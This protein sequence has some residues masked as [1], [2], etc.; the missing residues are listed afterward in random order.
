[1]SER[2]IQIRYQLRWMI[3][4]AAAIAAASSSFVYTLRRALDQDLGPSYKQ[5][6]ATLH[7]LQKVLLPMISLSVLVYLI[8]GSGI[9]ILVTIFISHS[10]AGPLFK[11]EQFAESL[12]RG[13]V[14]FPMRLRSGD[15]IGLLAESLRE[16]QGSLANRL[17]PFG[18]ALDRADRLWEEL[19][20]VDPQADPVRARELLA[21][22]DQELLAA[23]A[24]LAPPPA[25]TPGR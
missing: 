9:V 19:D 24:E 3:I 1:M 15:Q 13:E 10:I 12:R 11:M 20:A 2:E 22:L 14:N 6:Y 17:R 23:D 5:A 25:G 21:R 16:L 18:R 7:N 8:V 4:I